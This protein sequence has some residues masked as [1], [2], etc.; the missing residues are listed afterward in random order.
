MCNNGAKDNSGK[1]AD[2]IWLGLR[3][4]VRKCPHPGTAAMNDR[5]A[6]G[7]YFNIGE[8]RMWPVGDCDW[9]ECNERIFHGVDDSEL[10]H[11]ALSSCCFCRR[12]H[13][14]RPNN[15]PE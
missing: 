1:V 9:I 3:A 13:A 6:S 8:L 5:A 4:P 10:W 14:V 7:S 2:S 12:A 11:T 15:Q